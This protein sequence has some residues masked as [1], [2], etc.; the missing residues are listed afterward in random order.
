MKLS[1]VLSPL[2]A[3][4][5]VFACI[6]AASA[7]VAPGTVPPPA[8]V[9]PNGGFGQ[10]TNFAQFVT[11]N[12]GIAHIQNY[13]LGIFKALFAIELTYAVAMWIAQTKDS[14]RLLVDYVVKIA[15]A[16]AMILLIQNAPTALTF[17]VNAARCL[18]LDATIGGVSGQSACDP[19][20][21][22]SSSVATPIATGSST[23]RGTN[24]PPELVSG[25]MDPGTI[26]AFGIGLSFSEML[27]KP[28]G[29]TVGATISG[30][31]QNLARGDVGGAA[32]TVAAGAASTI[33]GT[34]IALIAALAMSI[35]FIMLGLEV[36]GVTMEAVLVGNIGI[37]F[38]GFLGHRWTAKYGHNFISYGLAVAARIF[39]IYVFI[40]VGEVFFWN[41]EQQLSA[42]GSWTLPTIVMTVA[43]AFMLLFMVKRM[44]KITAAFFKG[45]SSFS[46][47]HDVVIPAA[48]DAAA[49]A[50]G[51]AML[52]QG[53]GRLASV[54]K[55]L[56]KSNTVRGGGGGGGGA[57]PSGGGPGGPGAPGG[58]GG[59]NPGGPGGGGGSGGGSSAVALPKD[60]SRMAGGSSSTRAFA[61]SNE[62]STAMGESSHDVGSAPEGRMEAGVAGALAATTMMKTVAPA[63]ALGS[64]SASSGQR[65]AQAPTAPT[66][67][68]GSGGGGGSAQSGGGASQSSGGVSNSGGGSPLFEGDDLPPA[69]DDAEPYYGDVSEHSEAHNQ[70]ANQFAAEYFVE[71]TD[72]QKPGVLINPAVLERNTG[73]R[74]ARA[75]QY[76]NAGNDGGSTS[77]T[78]RSAASG[79][80][81]SS[82]AG[83]SGAGASASG[84]SSTSGSS[85]AAG[86]G[87]SATNAGGGGG[88][89]PADGTVTE[90]LDPEWMGGGSS[91]PSAP[92][93]STSGADASASVAA[94]A[95]EQR[96]EALTKTVNGIASQMQS[97][98]RQ[99]SRAQRLRA[100]TAQAAKAASQWGNTAHG[101]HHIDFQHHD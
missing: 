85:Q 42:S 27:G 100:L 60:L 79:A 29:N 70:R 36:A 7:Q 77:G 25:A 13:A 28:I 90:V 75:R 47:L 45:Q 91:R 98:G 23:N 63:A 33:L 84:S 12:A 68:A 1:R 38:L 82:P 15:Q 8:T 57:L 5:L 52:A 80:S 41:T 67:G 81:A 78:S 66:G 24:F 10:Q 39:V 2:V 31:G 30:A 74:S 92:G 101:G 88:G 40:G 9:N 34:V 20:Q 73:D 17:T 76:R 59:G 86:S 87:S 32:A 26:M 51:G 71:P 83:S 55:A 35:A 11:L 96:I 44:D 16:G 99:Q 53:A 49:V 14:N 95:M 6:A 61:T 54:A 64:S 18:A 62:S 89:D 46:G 58:P 56:G 4:G 37:I 94:A 22:G 19:Q 72:L 65:R 21:L 43:V 69:S 93:A 97:G 3:F 50:Y 48:V